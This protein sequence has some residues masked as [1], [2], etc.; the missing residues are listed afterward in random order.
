MMRGRTKRRLSTGLRYAILLFVGAV[1]LYPLLW[2]V[3]STFKTNIDMFNG[4]SLLPREWT[5][6][7]WRDAMKDYGGDLGIWKAMRHSNGWRCV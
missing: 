3:T 6:D 7:G 1:M 4:I 5:M 2:L